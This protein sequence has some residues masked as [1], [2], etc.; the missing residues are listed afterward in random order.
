MTRYIFIFIILL[1]VG[2]GYSQ[3]NIT[4]SLNFC[5]KDYPM[6]N[7]QI[8]LINQEFDTLKAL[9]DRKGNFKFK[10]LKFGKY[11]LL[12][13]SR[14]NQNILIDIKDSKK[15][16]TKLSLCFDT[17]SLDLDTVYSPIDFLCINDSIEIIY[18]TTG[19]FHAEYECLK[20]KKLSNETFL[21][22]NYVHDS[23]TNECIRSNIENELRDFLIWGGVIFSSNDYTCTTID[24]YTVLINDNLYEFYFGSYKSVKIKDIPEGHYVLSFVDGSCNWLGYNNLKKLIF[25]Y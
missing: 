5:D 10:D 2:K 6:A 14:Y 21:C 16:T 9:T 22:R 1:L 11:N 3:K 7:Y 20:I 12:Y 24:T 17:L 8:L 23:L 13:K 4:G 19:C 25:E 15:R 18:T